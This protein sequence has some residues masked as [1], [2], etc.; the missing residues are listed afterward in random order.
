[1]LTRIAILTILTATSLF[2]SGKNYSLSYRP[3]GKI[4][5]LTFDSCVLYT[6]SNS[7]FK[8]LK[9]LLTSNDDINEYNQ[10][11][12]SIRDIFKSSDTLAVDTRDY[13]GNADTLNNLYG[14]ETTAFKLIEIN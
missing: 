14:F 6:D 7:Y 2:A 13:K 5:K 11:C 10:L 4:I 3:T 12:K 9:S 8:A 1:M